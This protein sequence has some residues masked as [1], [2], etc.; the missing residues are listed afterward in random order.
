MEPGIVLAWLLGGCQ[1]PTDPPPASVVDRLQCARCH[2][3][4]PSATAVPRERSCKGCHDAIHAGAFDTT[5]RAEAV[6]R[7]KQRVVHFRDVPPLDGVARFQRDWVIDFVRQPVDLRP[8][9]SEGMV[10]V[11]LSDADAVV[12]ATDLGLQQRD[13]ALPD[14]DMARGLALIAGPRCAGCHTVGPGP[15][16]R[17]T[18]DRLAPSVARAW[19]TDPRSVWP[20][21]TMPPPGLTDPERQDVLAALY[22]G[23]VV[24]PTPRPMPTSVPP[25]T[26]PVD[27]AEVEQRV[28][29]HVCWHCHSDPAGNDGDGGPGNTGGFGYAGAGVEL[30]TRA[31]VCATAPGAVVAAMVERHAELA[32]LDDPA[33]L[34]MPLGLPPIAMA[35]IARVEAFLARGCP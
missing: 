1:P 28:F 31:G 20:N 21:A 3:A 18:R 6:A 32:G 24:A 19:L 29:H 5:H 4:V 14:G 22:R 16:L 26:D 23:P 9:L 34:G 15:D 33:R 10:P 2:P 27:W 25:P 11:P 30:G 12:L 8:G 13:E 35:D 17:F 7:W